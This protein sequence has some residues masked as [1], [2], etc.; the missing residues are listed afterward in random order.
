MDIQN[1]IANTVRKVKP[2]A[3]ILLFGSRARGDAKDSSDWDI[4]I[5]VKDR[6]ITPSVFASVGDPLYNLGIDYNI[7]INPILY[8]SYQWEK[9]HPSL[10]KYNVNKDSIE[11]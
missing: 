4:I 9:Q 7:E 3:R 6:H 11:L 1:E 2:D 8:T 5:I 10:F